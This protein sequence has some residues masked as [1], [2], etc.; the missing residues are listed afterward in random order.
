MFVSQK[1]LTD[2]TQD[3][4]YT[5]LIDG[6]GR[7][8]Y[9]K[10]S[11]SRERTLYQYDFSGNLIGER[12]YNYE[13]YAKNNQLYE[14][15][16]RFDDD[17]NLI[18]N[19]VALGGESYKT[20]F[21]YN[22][23]GLPTE[24]AFSSTRKV[25]YDYEEGV[26]VGRTLTTGTNVNETFS[27]SDDG[28]VAEHTIG[29]DVYSYEYDSQGNISSISKNDDLQQKY[30]YDAF[31]QLV[32]EDDSVAG[33]IVT[34]TYDGYG[35][36]LSKTE[37]PF[38]EDGSLGEPVDEVFYD[39][40]D[41]AWKDKLTSY[42]GQ[43]ITYDEIGNPTDYMGA[44]MTWLGRQLMTYSKDGTNI[45]YTYDADGLRTSKTVNGV[46]H[47][48]YYVDGQLMGEKVGNEYELW[49]RYDV[50]GNLSLICRNVI[51]TGT[52]Y[53]YYV[54]TNTRGDII[55]LKNGSGVTTVKY[56]YDAWG[57]LISVT[58]GNG[59]ALSQNSFAY[60][61]S[62]RYRGYVYDNETGLYYLQSRYYDPETG[63]FLNVDAVE[64]IGASETVLGY[65]TFAYCE[66]E[67]VG[68]FDDTGNDYKSMLQSLYDILIRTMAILTHKYTHVLYVYYYENVGS[69]GHVDFS[70]DKEDVI[71]YGTLV[72]D[73][74]EK[75]GVG[76]I[77]TYKY[78]NGGYF[79]K[80]TDYVA[81]YLTE[82]EYN[83][84]VEYIGILVGYIDLEKISAYSSDKHIDQ[85]KV[86][87]GTYQNYDYIF[88]NCATF[89]RNVLKKSLNAIRYNQATKLLNNLIVTPKDVFEI[90]QRVSNQDI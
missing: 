17:G 9:E 19:E 6:N 41:T 11:L 56:N 10:D 32:R 90:A 40:G 15:K 82:E 28:L 86:I 63:R 4:Y 57:K 78:D 55:E 53:Y 38:T 13:S 47:N 42:D 81:I 44:D 5:Y 74:I 66:N 87:R 83:S 70:Y 20:T 89:V 60:Q 27:Y 79:G 29:N 34:Y 33:K 23:N 45:S 80:Y 16:N 64:Y 59:V 39:Y 7:T 77:K 68:N 22:A 76:A 37:Y 26:L 52:K 71:S 3:Y 46:K 24:T 84:L 35:N 50:D 51:A 88:R 12:V 31:N 61:N 1:K 18:S 2:G 21:S 85:Y 8:L 72:E 25:T 48:Y 54:V 73:G 65:N 58:D 36:I 30:E 14:T 75:F 69:F 43:D 62:I 49:Y 67:P